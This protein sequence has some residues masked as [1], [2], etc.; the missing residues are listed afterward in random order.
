MGP[1]SKTAALLRGLLAP[2]LWRVNS[3]SC[4][5]LSLLR[6][7]GMCTPS[8]RK[9]HAQC[10]SAALTQAARDSNSCFLRSS[11]IFIFCYLVLRFFDVCACANLCF[12]M[13]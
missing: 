6:L 13:N 4:R 12:A 10:F 8:S 1:R 5:V 11:F 7:L 2:I 3:R 9:F